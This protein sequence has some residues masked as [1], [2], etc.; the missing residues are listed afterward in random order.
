MNS[1]SGPAEAAQLLAWYAE[2]GVDLAVEDAPQDR[3]A[4]STAASGAA[5][6]PTQVSRERP[7]PTLDRASPARPP[8]VVPAAAATP[9]QDVAVADA[10]ARAHEAR[11]LDELKAVLDTFDGLSLRKTATQLVFADGNPAAKVMFVGEAP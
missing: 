6:A 4:E 9:A 10:R 8:L 3:F 1:L 2:M 5:Q 11:S 7:L